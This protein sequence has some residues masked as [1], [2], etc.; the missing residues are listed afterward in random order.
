MS[1]L[2][3]KLSAGPTHTIDIIGA[4]RPHA[5]LGAEVEL[6]VGCNIVGLKNVRDKL[7]ILKLSYS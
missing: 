5:G 6:I 7:P 3:S 4:R 1:V 2:R